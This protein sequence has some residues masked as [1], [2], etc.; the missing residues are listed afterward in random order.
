MEGMISKKIIPI[1]ADYVEMGGCTLS[2]DTW[3]KGLAV[4]LLEVTH[5][6]WLY[7][8]IHVHDATSGMAAT[9]RKEE[10]QRFIEDQ[11][12]LGEEGLE[13]KD[14]YLLEVNWR[15]SN[16]RLEKN[17]TTGYS[18]FRRLGVNVL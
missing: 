14:H 4:K 13:E 10:I 3:A 11:I 15:T 18:T 1:Q 6:Q 16:T 12:Q 8:N 17:S 7:C 9:A 5:G 2:V